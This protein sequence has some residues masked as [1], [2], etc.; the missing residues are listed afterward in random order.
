KENAISVQSWHS[1]GQLMRPLGTHLLSCLQS[2]FVLTHTPSPET[3]F[4]SLIRLPF[5][6]TAFILFRLLGSR[7][8]QK[9]THSW[10]LLDQSQA[11][12]VF[13]THSQNKQVQCEFLKLDFT[14]PRNS[15]R[16]HKADKK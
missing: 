3:D 4:A 1:P 8:G 5:L 14:R 7:K 13:T 10:T 15:N 6:S 16:Q 2:C 12:R 9:W 11:N